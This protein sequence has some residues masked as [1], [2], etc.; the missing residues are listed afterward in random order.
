VNGGKNNAQLPDILIN[1]RAND[2]RLAVAVVG[3]PVEYRIER[4]DHKSEIG[5]VVLGRITRVVPA[6]E[7]AFV[8]IG[9]ARSGF[10]ALDGDR[11]REGETI[12]VEVIRDAEGGKGPKL[13]R[14]TDVWETTGMRPPRTLH[15]EPPLM[16]RTLRDWRGPVGHILVDDMA[17]LGELKK[18]CREHR[19]DLLPKL[20]FARGGHALE[21]DGVAD[22][23]AELLDDWVRLPSGGRIH[24][25]RTAALTAIDVDTGEDTAGRSIADTALRVD[26]EAA[27]EVA[28]QLRLR[29]LTGLVVVGFVPLGARANRARVLEALKRACAADPAIA[30]GGFTRFGLVE[31]IRERQRRRRP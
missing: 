21:T 27:A 7:A 25:G 31:L 9:D 3:E 12:I 24:V 10:L 11:P 5:N 16:E 6:L 15:G 13:A 1:V 2:A 17:A 14:N 29:D 23:L 8:D 19:P 18:F 26:L 22:R 20:A 30:V 28:R 4:K